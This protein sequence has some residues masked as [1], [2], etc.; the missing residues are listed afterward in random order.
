MNVAGG[1][2]LVL[3]AP[4]PDDEILGCGGY[5]AQRAEAGW[6]VVIIVLTR[7]EKLFSLGLGIHAQPSPDEVAALRREESRRA[8]ACLG[9]SSADLHFLDF[10]DQGLEDQADV[11]V[12]CL[13]PMLRASAPE[14]VLCT[15]ACE[16]HPDHVAAARITQR[17]CHA[18]GLVTR[19]CWYITLLRPGLTPGDLPFAVERIDTR[20]QL[21]RKTRAVAQFRA[22]LERISP[23]QQQPI[24]ADFSAYLSGE[25]ILSVPFPVRATAGQ[26]P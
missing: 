7:G 1:R 10:P 16:G 6:R 8:I 11:V 5:L 20:A 25:E 12:R 2:T 9:L 15:S 13:V 4:H 22:H 3:I 26:S 23:L 17:A 14:E 21:E 24:C 19:I 18:A